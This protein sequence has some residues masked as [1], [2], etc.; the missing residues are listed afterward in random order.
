MPELRSGGSRGQNFEDVWGHLLDSEGS[1]ARSLIHSSNLRGSEAR[2][3]I[4]SSILRGSEA[5]SSIHSS[6]LRGGAEA[7]ELR[8]Q[9]WRT[10]L[11]C[12]CPPPIGTKYLTLGP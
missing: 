3:S 8:E 2:S 9:G 7:Q 12:F 11:Y 1:E 10:G 4:H 6:N 5:R